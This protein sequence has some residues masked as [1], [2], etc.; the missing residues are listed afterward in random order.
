MVVVARW[1]EHR[2]RA[3]AED[4]GGSRRADLRGDSALHRVEHTTADFRTDRRNRQRNG[5]K[6]GNEPGKEEQNPCDNHQAPVEYRRRGKLSCSHASGDPTP[7]RS[8]FAFDDPRS[9][10]ADEDQGEKGEHPVG[11]CGE[12]DGDSEFN[13][14][15]Q[16]EPEDYEGHGRSVLFAPPLQSAET[17]P[18]LRRRV[19]NER[20]A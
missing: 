5:N 19:R 15:E 20:R 17:R 6:V 2:A 16:E 9:S 18:S 1:C 3:E 13:G 12:R 14:T 7:R 11:R 8:A 4:R 10:S